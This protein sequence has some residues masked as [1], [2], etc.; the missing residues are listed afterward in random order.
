MI[1]EPEKVKGF[2]DI[3]PPES[4]KRERVK[5]VIKKYFKLYGF[6]PVETPTIEYDEL[7]RS[8]SLGKEDEVI[9]DRFRLK[10]K[11]NRNLGLR[12][13][14]T[15]Q[16]KRLF[17]QNPNI[18]L[19]FKKYQIGKI[20]RDEPTGIGRF[21][22]FTQCDIDII[23]DSS[24]KSDT[25]CVAV[26]SDILKELK[27]ESEIQ[28]NNRK[29]LSAIIESVKI[30]DKLEVM[31]ELDKIEK[32]GEDSV[33]ANLRKYA[34]ANQIL[35]LFKMLE[36]PLDFFTKNLFDGAEEIKEL[37][38]LGKSYGMKTK[39]NPFMIRGLGYYTGNIFEIKVEGMK[40]SI[41][42]GG[43]YDDLVGKY[44]N[45]KIPAVGISF[46][47]ERLTEIANIESERTKV[48]L[49]SLNQDKE[50]IKLAKKLRKMEISCNTMFGKPGKSLDYT[51]SLEIPYAI[52]IGDEETKNKKFKL[53]EMSSG[54]EKLLTEKQLLNKLKK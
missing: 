7:M 36:K 1:F 27:L 19:P 2:Q 11:G 52:F 4:L 35:T 6:L 17:K 15:F 16:L 43:R 26:F 28:I 33:K 5:S 12:Y 9:S 40:N 49:I 44:L 51:N 48:T 20:F 50:T 38:T 31:R 30:N 34:N 22:E 41:G 3:L 32:V 8:D 45:K 24:I 37:E 21:R 29:L 42:G 25:E 18:K 39:F 14:L 23:G 13:E 46:G 54:D 10:D 53:K 47:L